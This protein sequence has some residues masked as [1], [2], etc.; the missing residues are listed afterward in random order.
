MR[1]ALEDLY[2]E[3][4]SG[5]QAV[6][7]SVT[8]QS[9]ALDLLRH[10]LVLSVPLQAFIT[11]TSSHPHFTFESN[12]RVLAYWKEG[13]GRSPVTLCPVY[14]PPHCSHYTLASDG[15]KSR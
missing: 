8:F 6:A 14:F 15:I 2:L 13:S 12:A 1:R 7:V 10:L 9:L 11:S 5:R 4:L 3:I